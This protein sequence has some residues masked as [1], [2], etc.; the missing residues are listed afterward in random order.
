MMDIEELDFRHLLILVFLNERKY[1]YN[2]YD[3]VNL[4]DLDYDILRGFFD[5]LLDIELIEK[6]YRTKKYILSNKGLTELKKRNLLNFN[7]EFLIENDFIENEKDE[8]YIEYTGNIL[9]LPK[10]FE[11]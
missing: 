3:I 4:L 8:K 9:Y 11:I 1:V 6:D 7:L 5:D 2:T 10:E